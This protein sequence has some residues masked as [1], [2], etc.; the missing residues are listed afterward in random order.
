M[1]R[2]VG[3]IAVHKTEGWW[4]R[5]DSIHGNEN[6]MVLLLGGVTATTMIAEDVLYEDFDIFSIDHLVAAFYDM[7]GC[8]ESQYRY[9]YDAELVGVR[10]PRWS[11]QELRG[12]LVKWGSE[13][14]AIE[15]EERKNHDM[16][17]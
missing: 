17:G 3:S 5:I 12:K 16:G 2:I 14:E 10:Q 13:V 15:A 1:S 4:A 8:L 6:R 11:I 7:R 9:L